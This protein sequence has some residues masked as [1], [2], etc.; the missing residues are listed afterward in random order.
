MA[1]PCFDSQ[2]DVLRGRLNNAT[3]KSLPEPIAP[4]Q[5]DNANLIHDLLTDKTHTVKS[6]SSPSSDLICVQR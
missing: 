1:I 2:L 3:T 4:H 6:G 5:I